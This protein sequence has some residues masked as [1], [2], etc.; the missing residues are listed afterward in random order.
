[1]SHGRL[2]SLVFPISSHIKIVI[3]Q[4]NNLSK[5]GKGTGGIF[6]L[7]I[8]SNKHSIP[9]ENL[10]SS[11]LSIY[12]SELHLWRVAGSLQPSRCPQWV[13]V[14]ASSHRCCCHLLQWLYWLNILHILRP[15][16]T[17]RWLWHCRYISEGVLRL[18]SLQPVL[19]VPLYPPYFLEQRLLYYWRGYLSQAPKDDENDIW[20]VGQGGWW[21]TVKHYPSYC[22][23]ILMGIQLTITDSK[24]II[25]WGI[26]IYTFRLSIKWQGREPLTHLV[27]DQKYLG[28]I[29]MHHITLTVKL[30]S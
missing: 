7:E 1:M 29:V 17:A 14:D 28:K 9:R 13:W 15:P 18:C 6:G 11:T 22:E 4:I 21:N 24:V 30:A 16:P 23:D 2:T 8:W 3:T 26:H 27:R 19:W 5:S 25:L 20:L 10:R 12:A